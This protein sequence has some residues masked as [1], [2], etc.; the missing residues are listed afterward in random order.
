MRLRMLIGISGTDF[1]LDPGAETDRFGDKEGKRLI[2]AGYAE[3]APP[4]EKKK[5]ESKKEWDEE[6]DA[7]I[8]ENEE[9]KANAV[10]AAER[11][12]TLLNRLDVLGVFHGSVAQAVQVLDLADVAETTEKADNRETRG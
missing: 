4:I 9:L 5:A 12:T 6:R 8:K 10:A 11:E 7:L 1:T 2:E 3:K